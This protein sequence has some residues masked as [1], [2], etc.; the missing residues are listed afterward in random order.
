MNAEQF[1]LPLLDQVWRAHN[2]NDLI[3]SHIIRDFL[4]RTRCDR[5]RGG[6]THHGFARPHHS[7]K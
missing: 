7:T 3:W 2:Q 4:H 6:A 1:A 5:N